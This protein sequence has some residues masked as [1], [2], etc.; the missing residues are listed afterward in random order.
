MSKGELAWN[1]YYD[2]YGHEPS[3]FNQLQNYAKGKQNLE[4]LNFQTAKD[5]F[6]NNKGKGRI[7]GF[8]PPV[9][10]PSSKKLVS[11]GTQEFIPSD[12]ENEQDGYEYYKQQPEP[13]PEPTEQEI[14]AALTS[15]TFGDN[16]DNENRPYLCIAY[17]ALIVALLAMIIA[18]I[19]L[20]LYYSG[21]YRPESV[22]TTFYESAAAEFNY[23]T[24]MIKKRYYHHTVYIDK[25]PD[26][27]FIF[28]K[29]VTEAESWG[30]DNFTMD[31]YIGNY[32]GWQ[33][34]FYLDFNNYGTSRSGVMYPFR[35]L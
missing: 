19:P 29:V 31:W 2:E 30:D 8:P 22:N 7:N 20:I 25:K 1:A 24:L 34:N 33:Y 23:E 35:D 17:T 28:D 15:M 12:T 6:N 16:K 26:F 3:N 21:D 18:V 13:D 5:T 27:N 32:N 14:T 10:V 9:P 4:N 11:P